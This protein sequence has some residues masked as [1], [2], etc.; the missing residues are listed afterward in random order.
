MGRAAD[1]GCGIG[2]TT[3][4]LAATQPGLRV[5]GIDL[6]PALIAIARAR[7]VPD[8]GAGM[9]RKGVPAAATFVVGDVLKVLPTLVP[10]DLLV[11]RHGLMFFTD[12]ASAFV[13]L[14]ATVTPGAPL[15]FS[16]FAPR[17]ENEWVTAPESAVGQM[18]PTAEGYAPGPL[19]ALLAASH[20]SDRAQQEAALLDLFA[21]RIREGAVTFS[22]A[23][24]IVTARAGKEA[25]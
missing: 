20:P 19:A 1:L 11:S 14:R 18:S 25:A 8:A 17:A 4:A 13:A 16:C 6:S 21:T 7:A 10:L 9:D 3:L 2:D 24:R 15:V 22:A 23:I 12:P 5:T